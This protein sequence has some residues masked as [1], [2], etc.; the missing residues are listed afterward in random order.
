MINL[1]K[2]LKL[3]KGDVIGIVATSFP[4][5]TDENSDYFL[6]YKKAVKELESMG[7]RVKEG[8]NLRKVKWWFAGTPQERAEDINSMFAD[9]EV[10][11]TIVHEGGQSAIATLEYINYDLVK[12]N[13]KPFIGFSDITN[14]HCALFTKVRMVGF[15]GGL[16]T[17]SLG[18]VWDEYL[19]D[20]KEKGK[21][22]LFNI[23]TSDNAFGKIEPLTKWEC[24]REGE[25]Q[26][27]L[28]GGNLAM[29]SSLVGTKY[30]PKLEYLKGCI[31]F[32]E[33]DNTPSYRIE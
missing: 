1:V 32:W 27:R 13:P 19:P 33:T 23:L 16:L 30:F 18:R 31:L 5:P 25:A 21:E 7:F 11:A 26:G 17:Y 15:H 2:P 22:L 14:I 9:T 3:Q 29:L 4:F 24:W 20:K 6:Q 12:V 8:K 28:F 10:K